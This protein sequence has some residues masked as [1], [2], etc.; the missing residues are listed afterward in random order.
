MKINERKIEI[1]SN[2]EDKEIAGQRL[3]R[4]QRR[5]LTAANA[6]V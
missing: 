4:R 3:N 5:F 1:A 2:L 6:K